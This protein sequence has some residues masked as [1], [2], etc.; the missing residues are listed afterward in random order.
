MGFFL[1]SKNSFASIK[2]AR[3]HNFLIRK[4]ISILI[5]FPF[6]SRRCGHCKSL[7]KKE[8]NNSKELNS[9]RVLKP[10]REIRPLERQPWAMTKIFTIALIIMSLGILG[11]N[12]LARSLARSHVERMRFHGF[13]GVPF[14]SSLVD[15]KTMLLFNSKFRYEDQDL[16]LISRAMAFFG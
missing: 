3:S 5:N 11:G 14:D 16:P 8:L 2:L 9:V 4:A 12:F 13:C 1:E 15:N 7:T 6:V 10:I